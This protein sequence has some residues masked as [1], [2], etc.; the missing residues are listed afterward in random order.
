MIWFSFSFSLLQIFFFIFI[1]FLFF[2]FFFF[3][4]LLFLYKGHT[5]CTP[6]IISEDYTEEPEA[7]SK[8][9]DTKLTVVRARGLPWQST[10]KDVMEFFNELKITSGGVYMDEDP[11]GRATGEVFV[12]FETAKDALEALS[13]NRRV[14]LKEKK[15][16]R[17]KKCKAKKKK[18]YIGRRYIEVFPSSE[19]EMEAAK[20][21]IQIF[22]KDKEASK[23]DHIVKLR[24]IPYSCSDKDIQ[25]FFGTTTVAKE[26]VSLLS[27]YFFLL[28]SFFLL[29]SSYFLLLSSYFFLLSS[30]FFLLSFF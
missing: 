30:F 27:S 11:N 3:L 20:K 24:G 13:R 5:Y 25:D 1:S 23:P 28:S 6:E 7:E 4:L 21:R 29:L 16:K 9:V 18:K 19:S 22:S 8:S 12:R 17:Q 10:E 26:K 15:E 14:K 2:F